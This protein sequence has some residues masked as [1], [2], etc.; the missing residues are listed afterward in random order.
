MLSSLPTTS[1]PDAGGS[2]PRPQ[3]EGRNNDSHDDDDEN[4]DHGEGGRGSA[5]SSLRGLETPMLLRTSGRSAGHRTAP[6]RRAFHPV[7]RRS[8]ANGQDGMSAA[9]SPLADTPYSPGS[10]REPHRPRRDSNEDSAAGAPFDAGEEDDDLLDDTAALLWG[11]AYGTHICFWYSLLA[12]ACL[13]FAVALSGLAF[14]FATATAKQALLLSRTSSSPS[15]VVE[16]DG[17]SYS[18]ARLVAITE[19]F[20]YSSHS[21]YHHNTYQ[22]WQWS[23]LLVTAT[24]GF[25][26]G[27]MMLLLPGNGN[28]SLFGASSPSAMTAAYTV[29]PLTGEGTTASPSMPQCTLCLVLSSAIA[30]ATG[31]PVGPE[32]A[33]G[34]LATSLATR[35]AELL[36]VDRRTKTLWVASSVAAGWGGFF[37]AVPLIG[38][39][40]VQES[41]A[42]TTPA[43]A[44]VRGTGSNRRR[45]MPRPDN[46]HDYVEGLALQV[47][48]TIVSAM[49]VGYVLNDFVVAHDTAIEEYSYEIWHVGAAVLIGLLCGAVGMTISFWTSACFLFRRSV[50]RCF[51]IPNA[52]SVLLFPTLAGALY[53]VLLV[54]CPYSAVDWLA[55]LRTLASMEEHISLSTRELT[56]AGLSIVAGMGVSLGFGIVG[57]A[58]IPSVLVGACLGRVLSSL[59]AFLPLSLTLPCCLA[60]CPV[61][62]FPVPVSSVV[63]VTLLVGTSIEQTTPI[64][65]ACLVS[66]TVTGGLGLV[67]RVARAESCYAPTATTTFSE[68]DR[69]NI[70]DEAGNTPAG[71]GLQEP[72][73]S[74]DEILSNV[75]SAI[76]GSGALT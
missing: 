27:L 19:G 42:L 48:A 73:L 4:D 71:N 33:V 41:V 70:F 37:Y 65:I 5:T 8:R 30:I 63:A 1:L 62:V 49:I 52:V 21:Q 38:P 72:L 57:G 60:A 14:C 31:A 25:V 59:V 9:V 20:S 61:S 17:T 11:R 3:Q 58:L 74:E 46:E 40:I 7:S 13:G 23:K 67:R 75:R 39:M 10:R 66:W 22:Q 54:S 34:V 29:R 24:G 32:F 26:A 16:E 2:P 47:A 69:R 53:G 45:Q 6:P 12:A 28:A 55:Q 51:R 68:I 35:L 56:F 44:A 36:D 64:L 50:S 76:F 18:I 15:L 43:A